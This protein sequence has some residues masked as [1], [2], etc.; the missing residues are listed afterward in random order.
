MAEAKYYTTMDDVYRFIDKI[1][2]RFEN[3]KS[4]KGVYGIPKGGLFLAALLSSRLGIP[5]LLAACDHGII[6]DDIADTGETLIHYDR[7]SSGGKRKDY[8][9][10]TM[11]YNEK[12]SSVVPEIFF[13]H[14]TDRW[15]VFPWE[16]D[17]EKGCWPPR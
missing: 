12:L 9:I 6:V 10:C 4:I 16:Y 13:E 3:D 7:N 2:E 1:A 15:I 14:K 5:M 8:H 11:F 17:R